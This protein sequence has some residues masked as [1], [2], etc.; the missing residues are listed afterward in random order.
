[1]KKQIICLLVVFVA[2]VTS[3]QNQNK[4]SEHFNLDSKVAIMGYDPVAYF[5]GK[6]EQGK[7]ELSA[8]YQG[9][10]YY[11]LILKNLFL[12]NKLLNY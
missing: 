9:I 3:A 4:R 10:V 1:M 6:P 11:F 8:A 12:K 5:K 7:K 2:A